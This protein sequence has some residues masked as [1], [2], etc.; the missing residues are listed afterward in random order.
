MNVNISVQDERKSRG[1]IRRKKSDFDRTLVQDLQDLTDAP[2]LPRQQ[3]HIP[4]STLEISCMLM[5]ICAYSD[6]S[7]RAAV[8]LVLWDLTCTQRNVAKFF[9]IRPSVCLRV[10]TGCVRLKAMLL[11]ALSHKLL[12]ML[13]VIFMNIPSGSPKSKGWR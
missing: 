6:A 10:F 9:C 3:K 8:G 12:I 7:L 2:S 11:A 1:F 4:G 13:S 5:F